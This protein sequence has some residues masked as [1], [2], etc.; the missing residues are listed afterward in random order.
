MPDHRLALVFAEFEPISALDIEIRANAGRIH[1]ML[2]NGLV[3]LELVGS[4]RWPAAPDEAQRHLPRPRVDRE[5]PIRTLQQIGQLVEDP[6]LVE[7]VVALRVG[8]Q[9]IVGWL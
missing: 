6:E 9:H 8:A 4:L 2:W 3:V 7:V 1:P 5:Q